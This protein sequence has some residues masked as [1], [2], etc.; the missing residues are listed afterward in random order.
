MRV[1]Y[2]FAYGILSL[3]ARIPEHASCKECIYT[4]LEQTA[5][6]WGVHGL[7]RGTAWVSPF[8][9]ADSGTLGFAEHDQASILPECKLSQG[10]AGGV[11]WLESQRGI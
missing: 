3:V 4:Q 1:S 9:G 6:F 2:S 10:L 7:A 11:L 5:L 8:G